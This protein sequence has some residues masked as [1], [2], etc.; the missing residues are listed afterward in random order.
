MMQCFSMR[1]SKIRSHGQLMYRLFSNSNINRCC[2]KSLPSK[3]ETNDPIKIVKSVKY[4]DYE[5]IYSYPYIRYVSGM[6][7]A[8]RTQTVFCGVCTVTSIGARLLNCI[9]TDLC[10]S[11]IVACSLTTILVHLVTLMCN[12]TIGFVYLRNN[13]ESVI[14]SYTNYWGERV[15]LK[16]DI[17]SIL[18]LSETP[19][20]L[21]SSIYRILNIKYRKE[22]LKL[23]KRGQMVQKEN[24]INIFGAQY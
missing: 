3:Q 16:T 20:N 12:N 9:S 22:Q 23:I 13:D 21:C 4:P 8:K 19:L 5:I 7:V 1:L 11:C 6:N 15:D 10:L 17:H 24:F 2:S 14:L 18:P